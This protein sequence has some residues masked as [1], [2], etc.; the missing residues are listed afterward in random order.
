MTGQ[1]SLLVMQMVCHAGGQ[2]RSASNDLELLKR[3]AE[4][5]MEAS[6][7]AFEVGETMLNVLMVVADHSFTEHF[8]TDELAAQNE[9]LSKKLS[10]AIGSA[11]D[12]TRARR[13]EGLDAASKRRCL[14]NMIHFRAEIAK[15]QM[16]IFGDNSG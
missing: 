11:P 3:K 8:D 14:A 1:P 9:N 4:D 15:S 5:D 10:V 7:A 12:E 16:S 13:G 6:A 2:R